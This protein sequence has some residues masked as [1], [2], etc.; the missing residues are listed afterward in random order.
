MSNLNRYKLYVFICLS[1]CVYVKSLQM[2]VNPRTAG[3]YVC[4]SSCVC[5]CYFILFTFYAP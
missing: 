4:G 2:R 3:Q 1:V 5:A